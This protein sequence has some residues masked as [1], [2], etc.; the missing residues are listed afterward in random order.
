MLSQTTIFRF[1]KIFKI[2]LYTK[3]LSYFTNIEKIRKLFVPELELLS[4]FRMNASIFLKKFLIH[5]GKFLDIFDF[6]YYN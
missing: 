6:F 1:K 4:F 5:F 2:F 3:F